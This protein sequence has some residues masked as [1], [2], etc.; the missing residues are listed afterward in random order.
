MRKL[1]ILGIS[2]LKWTNLMKSQMTKLPLL[3]PFLSI[4]LLL[5]ACTGDVDKPQMIALDQIESQLQLLDKNIRGVIASSPLD[6]NGEARII[7]RRI[8]ED[9]SLVV[10]SGGDWT[11]GFFPGTL[12]YMYELTGKDAWKDKAVEYTE[13]LEEQMYNGSNHD[14]GFRM[15]CSYGNALRLTADEA[16]IPVLVQSAKTLISRYYESVGSIRSWDFNP[17]VWQCP[18]IVDNMM[19]LELL[20]WASEQTGDPVYREIAIQH[21]ETTLKNHF[22]PDFSSYHVVD[23]DT[24]SGEVRQKNTHQGSSDESAWARGQA[25][26]LYGFTMTYRFTKDPR[27][28]ELAEGIA[29]FI[30]NHPRLPEDLIPYW[31]FDAP[32]IPNEERDASAGAI[33][34]SALYELSTYSKKGSFYRE[35]ADAM[36]ESLG[37]NYASPSGE[38]YGFILAHSVGHKPGGTEIDTPLNY[39]D[40]YFVEA[41]LRKKQLIN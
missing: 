2:K 26:G 40:Y 6:D 27:Y 9:G 33:I 21:A 4:L 39:A 12:W 18:V 7:P 1:V 34:A 8:A 35:K 30:L 20:F 14:V 38:N 25:W 13:K 15:Y 41:L 28:L 29:G 19:N 16:Y 36:L 17:A 11:S 5:F 32:E 3:I 10:Q 24:I 37:T 23:Y 22:R 31:D